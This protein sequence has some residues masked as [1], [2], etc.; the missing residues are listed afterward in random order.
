MQ[1]RIFIQEN[2]IKRLENENIN[3]KMVLEE[4]QS[5]SKSN[6]NNS[7]ALKMQLFNQ[8]KT[9]KKQI[10]EIN[11]LKIQKEISRNENLNFNSNNQLK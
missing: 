1:D 11:N 3:L 4:M 10:E 6:F 2:T 7:E 9:I 8:N 5:S